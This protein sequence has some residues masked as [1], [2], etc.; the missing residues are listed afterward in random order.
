MENKAHDQK[1]SFQ[2]TSTSPQDRNTFKIVRL[3]SAQRFRLY[4]ERTSLV[5]LIILLLYTDSH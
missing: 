1:I 4:S 2:Y 5:T 3:R